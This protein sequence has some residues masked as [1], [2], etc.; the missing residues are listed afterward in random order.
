MKVKKL[1]WITLGM[2]SLGIGVAGII[3]PILPSFPFLMLTLFSFT[4]S[5]ERLRKWFVST[6]IYKN[7]LE[8][9]V[10]KRAMSKKTKLRIILMV[11]ILMGFGFLMMGRVPVARIV[12]VCVW[13]FHLFFFKFGIKTLEEENAEKVFECEYESE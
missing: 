7:N 2:I 3:L 4:R 10:E 5:S 6:K 8:S 13:V 9:Y 1:L 12:L 11:T